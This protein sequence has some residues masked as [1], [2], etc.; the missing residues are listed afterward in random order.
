MVTADAKV[1]R[2]HLARLLP[3]EALDKPCRQLSGGMRRRVALVRAMMTSSQLC[4]LDEPFNGLDADSRQLAA[5][6]M[7]EERGGRT[8]IIAC[9]DELT[10]A[11]DMWAESKC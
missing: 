6:Y 8:M 10:F 4:L 3:E 7:K 11:K 2:Q 1:A 5:Q 9:H